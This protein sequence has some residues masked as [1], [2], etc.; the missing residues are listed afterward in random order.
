MFE[1]CLEIRDYFS[2]YLDGCC[3]RE[4][5]RSVRFHLQYCGACR[6][7]L[8]RAESVQIALSELPRRAVPAAADLRLKVRVSQELN[9]NLAARLIVRVQNLVQDGL[10]PASGGFAVALVCFCLFLGALAVPV[11]TGPEVPLWF[12]TPAQ[13]LTLAPFAFEPGGEPVTVVTDIDADGRA[14]GFTVVSGQSSPALTRQLDQLLHSSRFLPATW[15]G[16]PTEGKVVLAL[17]EVT[18]RG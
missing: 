5:T 6:D 9:R 10:L 18:V 1:S 2:D 15:F 3:S 7:E 11:N 12:E 14:I 17:R 4:T 8:E 16:K 13:V